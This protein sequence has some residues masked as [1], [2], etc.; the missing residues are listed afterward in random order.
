MDAVES[1]D[2]ELI[3]E[4][5]ESVRSWLAGLKL[6]IRT[7][8]ILNKELSGIIS[9]DPGNYIN[10]Q[11]PLAGVTIAD[12]ISDLHSPTGGAVARVKSVGPGLLAEL[13]A[14]I[15]ADTKIANGRAD[16]EKAPKAEPAVAQPVAAATPDAAL[17]APRRPGRPKGS[18]KTSRDQAPKEE[19]A[20]PTVVAPVVEAIA[21]PVV[22]PPPVNVPKRRGRPPRAAQAAVAAALPAPE[23]VVVPAAPPQTVEAP[24]VAEVAPEEAPDAP[25]RRGRPKGSTNVN[26]AAPVATSSVP[27]DGEAAKPARRGRPP[28][29]IAP[30]PAQPVTNGA[31][32]AANLSTTTP[33]P[34]AAPAESTATAPTPDNYAAT[35]EQITRIWAGLHPQAR[36]AIVLYASTLVVESQ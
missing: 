18:G 12:F 34:V 1:L 7:Y 5:A 21:A 29:V 35:L 17:A 27:P 28:R 20:P 6:S 24:P 3:V 33:A 4:R 23:A 10:G 22:E 26:R 36:R 25:R 14:A 8:G 9:N 19:A 16:A 11:R 2:R 31:Q 30:T 15:P 32:P 13:R